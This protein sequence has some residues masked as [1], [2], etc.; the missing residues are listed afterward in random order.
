M[1]EELIKNTDIQKI[2]D[3]GIKIYQKIKDE[4]EP[5]NN[6]KFLAIDIETEKV[7]LGDTTSEAVEKARAVHP[8]K[9]FYVVKIG[10]P[11]SE[12]LAELTI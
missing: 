3:D 9:V 5:K 10:Y 2:S 12:V 4:Y 1:N 6:E 7:Y 8:E 11:F